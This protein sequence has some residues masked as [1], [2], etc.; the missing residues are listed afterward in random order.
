MTFPRG[1]GRR[2]FFLLQKIVSFL[3]SFAQSLQR[4]L[5]APERQ[6]GLLRG[7]AAL[8]SALIVCHKNV[9]PRA[10]AGRA[11]VRRFVAGPLRAGF[12]EARVSWIEL[13]RALLT[14]P[15]SPGRRGG[16]AGGVGGREPGPEGPAC[17]S[18]RRVRALK[19]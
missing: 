19:G 16:V 7:W 12:G 9:S 1:L 13:G 11:R 17:G 10:A 18:N 6:G 4:V 2:L 5:P 3:F 8:Q 15:R 14:A